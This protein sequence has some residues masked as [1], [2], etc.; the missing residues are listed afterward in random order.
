MYDG[1]LRY[2]DLDEADSRVRAA[3]LQRSRLLSNTRTE[4]ERARLRL[5]Q[6]E[7][8][9]ERAEKAA[10][11]AE[12]RYALVETQLGAGAARTIDLDEANDELRETELSVIRARLD[13]DLAI[14]E[15]S[16]AA[17]LE[18]SELH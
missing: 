6:A 8:G 11:L 4:V 14:L 15:L 13:R 1:G 17:G 5:K 18:V 3:R 2:A 10:H 7:L 12:R 16:Y 9:I